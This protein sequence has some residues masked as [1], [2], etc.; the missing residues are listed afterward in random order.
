MSQFRVAETTDGKHVGQIITADLAQIA[1]TREFNYGGR[2]VKIDTIRTRNDGRL[3]AGN[4]HY[5]VVLEVYE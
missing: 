2:I 1:T 5:T 3:L 4:S